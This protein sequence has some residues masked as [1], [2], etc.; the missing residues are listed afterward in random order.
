MAIVPAQTLQG[1]PRTIR[2]ELLAEFD[3]L[4]RNYRERRWEPAELDGGRFCEVTYTVIKGSIDG[5]FPST[6]A[7]PKNFLDACRRLEQASRDSVPHSLRI[8]IP[9]LISGLYDIRNNRGVGHIGGDVDSNQMDATL[10]VQIA[11][12]ILAELIRVH[13]SV[14]IDEAQLVVE[15][16]IERV[17]PV[18]WE[19]PD[20]RLRVLKPSLS[21]RQRMLVVLYHS[22]PDDMSEVDLVR[23]VEHS[24]AS[25]L[26]RDVLRPAH[27]QALINYDEE[28][29]S[30]CLSPLG[31]RE[32]EE[33][34]DLQV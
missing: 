30:V 20:G 11:T 9:R 17:V 12:W 27:K 13:H 19:L 10:V 28:N 33:Q 29:R 32:V 23:A 8:L 3:K 18:V 15:G 25:V 31:V 24:N 7:K 26:R 16:L 1:I 5:N 22:Y 6:A 4:V 14:T 21:M 34:I 2:E